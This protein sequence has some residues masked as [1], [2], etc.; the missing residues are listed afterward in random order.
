[1]ATKIPIKGVIVPNDQKDIYE[2]FGFDAVSPSDVNE[3]LEKAEDQ[4]VEVVIN[5]PGGD[6]YSGSEIY[7][8]LMDYRGNIVVKIVGVAA[9]AAS[10][11]G[12][13]GGEVKI[14]PTAQIMIHNVKSRAEG[15]YRDMKHQKEVLENYNKSIANAYRLKT[16]MSESELLN[17]MD[18]ETWLSAQQAKEYGFADSIMF[19]TGQ[20]L[21]A[22]GNLMLPPKVIK[23]TRNKLA[24]EVFSNNTSDNLD[25]ELERCK[26]KL[27]LL[28]L[29]GDDV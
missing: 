20:K 7:T 13:A 22:S 27:N 23:E 19:D 5:S 16:D 15:D 2:L 10:V 17:L 14:S 29:K 8:S 9:S 25:N 12:M 21:A 11:A 3:A 26:A 6:V 4:N 18:K 24:N 28:K 1:M